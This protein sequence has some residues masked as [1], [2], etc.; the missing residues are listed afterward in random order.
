LFCQRSGHAKITKE[1]VWPQ[2][3]SALMSGDRKTIPTTLRSTELNKV[4]KWK[5]QGLQVNDVCSSC[6]NGWMSELENAI[7]PILRPLIQGS[8][9]ARPI[10]L[11]EQ[12]LT[13]RWVLKL[14]M[15]MDAT[16]RKRKRFFT[17]RE[18]SQV[19]EGENEPPGLFFN[20]FLGMYGDPQMGLEGIYY[21]FPLPMSAIGHSAI[22]TVAHR[23]VFT[24]RVGK[25]ILQGLFHHLGSAKLI[26]LPVNLSW[27]KYAFVIHPFTPNLDWP[28]EPLPYAGFVDLKDRWSVD[29]VHPEKLEEI[30]FGKREVS[31]QEPGSIEKPRP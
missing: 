5:G 10:T 13:T 31:L 3:L 9:A 16:A 11:A 27:N 20:V 24:A 23:A 30:M 21:T 18:R 7:K 6:N 15:M 29:P 12:V 28:P 1:H 26:R 14:A 8:T 19:R 25:L 17:S 2:W 22:M 4:K